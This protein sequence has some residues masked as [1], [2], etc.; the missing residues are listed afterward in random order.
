MEEGDHMDKCTEAKKNENK[1]LVTGLD[2]QT[3]SESEKVDAIS[4]KQWVEKSFENK[5]KE[6]DV[7]SSWADRTENEAKDEGEIRDSVED[8]EDSI[9][10]GDGVAEV[11]KN[12]VSSSDT[13]NG[14]ASVEGVMNANP[15]QLD[16][17]DEITLE[18]Q[19]VEMA[20]HAVIYVDEELKSQPEVH[21]VDNKQVVLMETW[22]D[23]EVLEI[24]PITKEIQ[25]EQCSQG[26]QQ[27]LA[28]SSDSGQ[29]KN[30]LILVE[31]RSGNN[32]LY[33]NKNSPNKV[34]HDLG[35]HNVNIVE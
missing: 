7:P 29:N 20:S 25:V 1:K 28:D 18:V 3:N 16:K 19:E 13:Q 15:S 23:I 27:I 9:A 31:G 26:N 4:T 11:L 34:L 12:P 5:Q 17:L 14:G 33:L 35:F 32:I 10:I 6:K 30:N 2:S 22:E 21:D 8:K 24:K